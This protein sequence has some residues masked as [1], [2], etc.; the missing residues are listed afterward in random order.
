VHEFNIP[1]VERPGVH[2]FKAI[3]F[4]YHDLIHLVSPK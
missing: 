1:V 3:R 2:A 4:D